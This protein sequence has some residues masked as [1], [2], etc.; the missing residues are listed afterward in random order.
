MSREELLKALEMFARNWLAHDGAWFLAAE[1][2]FQ[3]ATA[4]ELDAKAWER[5][6]VERPQLIPRGLNDL[7][8]VMD[9]PQ[10][11]KFTLAQ[12]V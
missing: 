9:R 1:E 7:S 8:S 10:V 4:I 12:F 6:A 5:F 3:L 2:R 11:G